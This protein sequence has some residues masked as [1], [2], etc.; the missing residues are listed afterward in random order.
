VNCRSARPLSPNA[1]PPAFGPVVALLLA[2]TVPHAVA[3]AELQAGDIAVIA[4]N[5]DGA[6]DFAWVALRPL[7]ANTVIKFT[8]SSVSNGWFRW[9]E[10]LGDAWA[11]PLTWTCTNALSAGTVVRWVVNTTTNWSVGQKSGGSM[12]LATDGDQIFVYTGAIVSNAVLSSPWYGDPGAATLIFGL[13]F[14]NGGWDNVKGGETST[15]FVPPGLLTNAHTAVHV[16]NRDDGYYTGI[17]TGTASQLRQ[18][19]ACPTNWTTGADPYDQTNWAR[20]FE[21][22]AE[23][24]GTILS[25]W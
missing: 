23:H 6:D 15:S 8:D 18:A 24:A 14:A 11:G 1:V 17:C 25:A 19:I 16:D 13:N 9:T 21:V 5:T 12:R 2:L 7:P 22:L 10:H 20:V 3:A 4:Y